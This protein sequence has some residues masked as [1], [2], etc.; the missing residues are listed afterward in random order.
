MNNLKKPYIKKIFEKNK[1]KFFYVDGAWIREN[2]NEE[3]TTYADHL[4]FEFIPDGEIWIEQ[5]FGKKEWKYYV[6]YFLAK[7]KYL[8]E[9]YE[10]R[11]AIKL[12]NTVEQNERNKNPSVK[13]LKKLSK[14]EQVKAIHKKFLKK[15]SN[16]IKVWIVNGFLVRSLYFL[17][18]CAG[19]HDKVYHFIPEGEI[20]IDDALSPKD[21]KC[22]LIHE[23]HERILMKKGMTYD[24]AHNRSSRLELY[25]RKHPRKIDRILKKQ[26][27]RQ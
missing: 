2:I 11:T 20:W 14:S 3:F 9:F 13:R 8:N 6:K 5:E 21:L 18:Y 12:A 17:D 27:D 25:C 1:Y 10:Y 4:K 19:G 15:Y 22:T 26:L 16:K 7:L 24:K 23:A